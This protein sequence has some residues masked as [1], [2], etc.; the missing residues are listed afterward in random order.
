[1][2]SLHSRE[3]AMNGFIMQMLG[4]LVAIGLMVGGSMLLSDGVKALNTRLNPRLTDAIEEW[5]STYYPEY[6]HFNF[7]I[8]SQTESSDDDLSR[9]SVSNHSRPFSETPEH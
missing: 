8:T 2:K 3:D 5:E 4:T 9:I 6:S 1:M 7:S